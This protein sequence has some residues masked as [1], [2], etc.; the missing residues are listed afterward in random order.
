MRMAT[1]LKRLLD[2]VQQHVGGERLR[3]EL[4]RSTLHRLDRTGYVAIT[5]DEDDRHTRPCDALL[6]IEAIEFWKREVENDAAGPLDGQSCEEFFRRD[7]C[8]RA[9]AAR[10]NQQFQRLP[11]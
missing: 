1:P 3:Q 7:K 11:H 8:L 5:S 6:K 4:D 2:R 10:A 9:P